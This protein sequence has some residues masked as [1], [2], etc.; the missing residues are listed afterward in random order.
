MTDSEGGV[1]A[2]V[3]FG[4]SS[5]DDQWWKNDRI[6]LESPLTCACRY[7]SEAFWIN[8]HGIHSRH[9]NPFLDEIN[10]AGFETRAMTAAAIVVPIHLPFGQIGAVSFNPL[11]CGLIDLDALFRE[12]GL[13]LEMMARIFVTSYVNVT[14]RAKRL[15]ESRHSGRRHRVKSR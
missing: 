9:P 7:E 11:E 6:A 4:W 10:L 14:R 8:S 15:P 13:W 1:L 3:V 12:H 2:E 5:P